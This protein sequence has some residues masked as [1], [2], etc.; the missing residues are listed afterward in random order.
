MRPRNPRSSQPGTSATFHGWKY[1]HT[2]SE[3]TVITMQADDF[4]EVDGKDELT[5]VTLDIYNKDGNQYDHVKSA[6]AEFD[7]ASRHTLFRGRRGN[8]DE[9][10][11]Q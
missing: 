3:K 5:G 8:H 11:G 9:C 1:S 10:A 7:S 4:Q 2:S 6:K